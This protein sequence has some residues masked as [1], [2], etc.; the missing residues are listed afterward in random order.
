MTD[1]HGSIFSLVVSSDEN[2]VP[3]PLLWESLSKSQP[4][5]TRGLMLS[6]GLRSFPTEAGDLQG[7]AS[8]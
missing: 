5:A 3:V 6:L 8:H 4:Q 2:R 7:G 1:I